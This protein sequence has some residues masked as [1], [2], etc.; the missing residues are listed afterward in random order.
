MSE[1][2]KIGIAVDDYK[3]N[4][5]KQE[6]NK[7]GI[8]ELAIVPIKE[9]TSAITFTIELSEVKKVQKVCVDLQ[10]EFD[11]HAPEVFTKKIK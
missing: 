2:K 7:I 8:N 9:C 3:L 6:L 10:K 1:Y 4:R 5:F 11:S